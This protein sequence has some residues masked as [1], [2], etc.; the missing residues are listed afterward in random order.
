MTWSRELRRNICSIE[1][2][3]D[4][5]RLSPKERRQ[6]ESVITKHPMSISRYYMSLVQRNDPADPLAR[7]VIPSVEELHLAGSYDPSGELENT[8]MP[9]LQHKYRQTVLILAT[10]R[11]A[12]YC[13]YCFRKRLV[14]LDTD[15]II[16]RLGSAVRYIERHTEVNNVLISGGDPFVLP[17]KVI[18]RY[19]ERL[20]PIRHPKFIR[21]GTRT[22]AMFPERI[23]ED[24]ELLATFR[25]YSLKDRRIYVVTQF[26]HPRE[27]TDRAVDAVNS[28]IRSGVI[29]NNQ[30][31]LLKGVNDSAALLAEL[32]SKLVS[33]G[34][35]P[36]YVFQV[37][38][39]KRVK[40]R[41]QV[42]LRRGYEVVEEAKGRLDG[43]S[44]RFRY[45]MSHRTGKIEIVGA[46]LGQIH[47]RYHQAKNPKNIGK[48]F[49]IRLTATAG[50]LDDLH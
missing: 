25:K 43:H 5:S 34:V 6:L 39:V 38:P 49:H 1:G 23:V 16:G 14:G 8:K 40:H 48:F 44:K 33:V 15:E 7:M 47:L 27:I 29:M 19:L 18:A 4:Y 9:G 42:S 24:R 50:W 20:S 41:F 30:T 45:V 26:N 2:L 13:R 28:L 35:N 22:P 3:P 37:R 36:Y 10:N 11:C 21:F 17:T 31:V 12:G 46:T 32:Q